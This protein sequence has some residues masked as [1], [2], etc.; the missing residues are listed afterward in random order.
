MAT[1]GQN[2]ARF[3]DTANRAPNMRQTCA[4]H[5]PNM[6]IHHRTYSYTFLRFPLGN[7]KPTV[8]VV[9]TMN[10]RWQQWWA[11]EDQN[12]HKDFHLVEIQTVPLFLSHLAT[13]DSVVLV[14]VVFWRL[15]LGLP[16][17]ATNT[18][19]RHCGSHAK[20]PINLHFFFPSTTFP[21][22]LTVRTSQSSTA[23]VALHCVYIV[24]VYIFIWSSFILFTN[25]CTQYHTGTVQVLRQHWPLPSYC[26]HCV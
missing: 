19:D 11:P 6:H 8:P 1:A 24:H 17:L 21:S 26:V 3:T 2:L 22:P 23:A 7:T 10:Q 5:A 9:V 16:F 20:V 18:T 4:T 14:V 25:L 13:L 15:A 12:P